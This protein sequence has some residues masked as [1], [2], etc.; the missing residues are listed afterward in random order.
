MAAVKV[1][2]K[3]AKNKNKKSK[4]NLFQLRDS[5]NG[6]KAGAEP[7][8]NPYKKQN[9]SFYETLLNFINRPPRISKKSQ[10]GIFS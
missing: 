7:L 10:S 2:S 6:S 3:N 5:L 4:K 1:N 8:A 9:Q